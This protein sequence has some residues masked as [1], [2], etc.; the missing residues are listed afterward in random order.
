[1][2]TVDTLWSRRLHLRSSAMAVSPGS[3]VVAERRSRLVHLDPLTGEP[4]WDQQVEDC[5]GTAVIA[6]DRCLYLSRSGTLHCLDLTTGERLWSTPGLR[7]YG[8]LTVTGN[9]IFTG[10]WRGYRPLTRIS[11]TTGE[12]LPAGKTQPTAEFLP[13]GEAGPT[14]PYAWP[15]PVRLANG[16]NTVLLA[17]AEHSALTAMSESGTVVAEWPLPEP[18]RFP[19]AQA[20]FRPSADG[21]F[22]FLSGPRT[23]MAVHPAHGMRILGEH[24]RD[25]REI[26]PMLDGQTWWLVDDAGIA[27]VDLDRG[28]VA[29]LRT[30]PRGAVM[31]ATLAVGRAWF[32]F[33]DGSLLAVDRSGDHHTAPRLLPQV[34]RLFAGED[35]LI[36]A[37]GQGHLVTFRPRRR[38]VSH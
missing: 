7:Y 18:V 14:G 13:T 12:L 17:D 33:T 16:E 22:T 27:V 28:L 2:L 21:W 24:S 31:A 30:R 10:G 1:M 26:P 9:T 36:H 35:G 29:E 37:I 19:D 6:H 11:L 3:V 4:R 20:A 34:D 25:L 38:S 8:H 32:A 23:I 5:W 15:L